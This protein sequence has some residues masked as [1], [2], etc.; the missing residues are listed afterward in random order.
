MFQV[1][2]EAT[3]EHPFFVYGRGWSSHNPERTLHRYGLSCQ[4]LSVGDVC[5]SLT[6]KDSPDFPE[7]QGRQTRRTLANQI[8]DSSSMSSLHHSGG[9]VPHRM[10][11]SA[12]SAMSRAGSYEGRLARNSRSATITGLPS[13]TL[14]DTSTLTQGAESS[15]RVLP[16]HP[17]APDS[18]GAQPH[19]PRKR[20]WSAPDQVSLDT[21]EAGS[22]PAA[23]RE[24]GPPRS[25]AGGESAA[26][27]VLHRTSTAPDTGDLT[28]T[29]NQGPSTAPHHSGGEDKTVTQG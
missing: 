21:E 28:T 11:V 27:G 22:Q 23:L 8:S 6:H 14:A 9:G 26:Q 3:V 18:R 2:V 24:E 12:D 1:T 25:S 4:K 29:S 10:T 17:G 16:P 13:S 20:R 5:I 15:L 19:R 7:L